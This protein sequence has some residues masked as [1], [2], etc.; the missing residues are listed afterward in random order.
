MGGRKAADGIKTPSVRWDPP[1]RVPNILSNIAAASLTQNELS[2]G[3]NLI[4]RSMNKFTTTSGQR[5]MR[6]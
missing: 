1:A 4:H 2:G 6:S 3:D 5:W